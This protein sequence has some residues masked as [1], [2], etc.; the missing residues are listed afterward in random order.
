[1]KTHFSKEFQPKIEIS[2]LELK[3]LKG[4]IEKLES[5]LERE[6]TKEGKE[7]IIKER[8]R[9]Y[10]K[11]VQKTPTFAPSSKVRDEA[12]EIERFSKSEQVGALVSLALEKGLDYAISVAKN[13]KNPAIL[14]EFHDVIAD[15]YFQI[16]VEKRVIKIL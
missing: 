2:E 7:K 5:Q 1:M 16:L 6:K 15:R 10:F 13:L 4:R 3:E 8:I 12:K 11:E 14:D 9:E